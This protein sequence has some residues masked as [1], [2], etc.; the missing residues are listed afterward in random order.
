MA[1]A[2]MLSSPAM[3][4]YYKQQN[5]LT[6]P[7]VKKLTILD[8]EMSN[9]LARSDISPHLKIKMYHDVLNRFQNVRENVNRNP[10]LSAQ[11]TNSIEEDLSNNRLVETEGHPEENELSTLKEIQ[12]ILNK[13]SVN[14]K[15]R[16]EKIHLVDVTKKQKTSAEK[17][18][19]SPESTTH[20]IP[21]KYEDNVDQAENEKTPPTNPSDI[22]SVATPNIP[23]HNEPTYQRPSLVLS[24]HAQKLSKLLSNNSFKMETM[25]KNPAW[26]RTLN[27]ITNPRK[28]NP[29]ITAPEITQMAD[30]IYQHLVTQNIPIPGYLSK[31]S[32]FQQ[33]QENYANKPA[34]KRKKP[35]ATKINFARW[36]ASRK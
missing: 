31:S 4:S 11:N 22:V 6:N 12:T 21:V 16:K 24:N 29:T 13:M 36:D 5:I 35:S 14:T 15:K 8:E 33:L 19:N 7:E 23:P 3:E 1:Q 27:F 20:T 28:D 9:I 34:T 25:E 17:A 26:Q 32:N 30:K 10:H 18:L 2:I